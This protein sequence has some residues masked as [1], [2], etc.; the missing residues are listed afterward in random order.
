LKK[1]KF[2]FP[3]KLKIGFKKYWQKTNNK[4]FK[5]QAL[6]GFKI[7]DKSDLNF[8]SN[9]KKK[10]L[11]FYKRIDPTF[12]TI[13]K[14]KVLQKLVPI[15]KP[16]FSNKLSFCWL[17]RQQVVSQMINNLFNIFF[18]YRKTTN[19]WLICYKGIEPYLRKAQKAISWMDNTIIIR[20]AFNVSLAQTKWNNNES[21]YTMYHLE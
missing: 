18:K 4:I 1:W 19:H 16:L 20:K 12:H 10:S 7:A 15:G 13:D 5:L 8:Y 2:S 6:Q 14:K 21:Q 3:Q 11:Y 9:H 17:I